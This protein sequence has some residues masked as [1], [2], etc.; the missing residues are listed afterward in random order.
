MTLTRKKK[1]I[2][3]IFIVDFL[4]IAGLVI[5]WMQPSKNPLAE[6]PPAV[7]PMPDS[8]FS[9]KIERLGSLTD[10]RIVLAEDATQDSEELWITGFGIIDPT[11]STR[12]LEGFTIA[13]PW[14]LLRESAPVKDG[15]FFRVGDMNFDGEP[16][17][18]IL[19]SFDEGDLGEAMNRR[20]EVWVFD[21]EK[22]KFV[23]DD[24]LSGGC[25]LKI[26]TEKKEVIS[27]CLN[28]EEKTFE[29][30]VQVPD[31]KGWRMKLRESL[32]REVG[33]QG[34]RIFV[35]SQSVS[36]ASQQT[37][38]TDADA[39]RLFQEASRNLVD[40]TQKK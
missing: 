3:A 20:E 23:R 34:R 26:D 32:E 9:R 12:V 40:A 38:Q 24:V 35:R 19:Q 7:V 29:R 33:G 36:G 1:W 39:D 31:V 17:V 10:V 22:S 28:R 11:N 18:R 8:P 27:L 5:Y 4:L 25:D 30:T 37:V 16:D 14:P 15:S 2:L 21:R 6:R 13:R